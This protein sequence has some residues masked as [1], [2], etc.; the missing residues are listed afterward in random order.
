MEAL[1][2]DDLDSLQN[3]EHLASDLD[4]AD[5]CGCAHTGTLR[6]KAQP[7]KFLFELVPRKITFPQL[8]KDRIGFIGQDRGGMRGRVALVLCFRRPPRP[9][10]IC[11]HMLLQGD[12]KSIAQQASE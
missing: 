10:E 4:G 3:E 7:S 9:A 1:P 8:H 11:G 12:T 5:A 6:K 2:L